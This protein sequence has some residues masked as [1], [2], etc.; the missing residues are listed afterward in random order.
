M[1]NR[2][3]KKF[4]TSLIIREMQMKTA[5]KYSFTLVRIDIIKSTNNRCWRRY[6]EK[7]TVLHCWW[8]CKLVQPLWKTVWRQLRT[9]NIELPYG[10]A[11]AHLGIYLDKTFIGKDTCTPIFI[12]ALFTIT[13]KWKKPKCPLTDK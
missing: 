10:P 4:S 1:A 2:H 7:G 6:R 5:M 8:E 12:A 9:G 11:I 3:M 13:K